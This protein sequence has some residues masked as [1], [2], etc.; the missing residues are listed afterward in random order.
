MPRC[1]IEAFIEKRMFH[2]KIEGCRETEGMREAHIMRVTIFLHNLFV[3]I[4]ITKMK[5]SGIVAFE[6]SLYSEC[7]VTVNRKC[8]FEKGLNEEFC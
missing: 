8:P 4:P 3:K 1:S 5:V 6:R 7:R 2:L